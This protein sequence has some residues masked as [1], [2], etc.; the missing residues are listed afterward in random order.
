MIFDMHEKKPSVDERT[1]NMKYMRHKM[2]RRRRR[3]KGQHVFAN[4]I[5]EES[6]SS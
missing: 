5:K 1:R 2:E 4:G 6:S 3:V